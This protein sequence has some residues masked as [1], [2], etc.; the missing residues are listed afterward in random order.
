LKEK[1]KIA[2]QS[3]NDMKFVM[4]DKVKIVEDCI[5]QAQNAE[6]SYIKVTLKN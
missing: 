6:K 4:K 5:L 1:V 2:E 3:Y